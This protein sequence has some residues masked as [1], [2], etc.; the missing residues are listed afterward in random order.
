MDAIGYKDNV[1]HISKYTEFAMKG[2]VF[3]L[4]DVF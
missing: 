4:F 2:D 3:R 1:E